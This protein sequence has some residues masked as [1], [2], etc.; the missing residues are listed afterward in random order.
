MYSHLQL[1]P[2]GHVHSCAGQRVLSVLPLCP[3]AFLRQA[4]RTA[5][6]AHREPFYPPKP[7]AQLTGRASS[8]MP[9]RWAT[10]LPERMRSSTDLVAAL[11]R[12]RHFLHSL[13]RPCYLERPS[14][15]T[16]RAGGAVACA[17]GRVPCPGYTPA[18]VVDAV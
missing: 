7:Y 10:P 3:L 18:R 9:P 16:R 1:A 13:L 4:W 15:S 12:Q 5:Y 17:W 14:W 2:A 11:G 6:G 8:Q